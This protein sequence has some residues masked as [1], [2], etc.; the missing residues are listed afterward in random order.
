M[1]AAA[2]LLMLAGLDGAQKQGNPK[3]APEDIPVTLDP[4][5]A[6]RQPG[7]RAAPLPR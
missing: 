5:A 1:M 7:R 6:F 2:E 3:L 4:G